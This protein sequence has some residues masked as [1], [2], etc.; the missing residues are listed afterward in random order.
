MHAFNA[1]VSSTKTFVSSAKCI[2]SPHG[3]VFVCSTINVYAI[4]LEGGLEENTRKRTET[5]GKCFYKTSFHSRAQE[6]RAAIDQTE[7]ELIKKC[8]PVSRRRNMIFVQ[9]EEAKEEQL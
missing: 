7:N 9:E 1:F 5:R 3:K 4:Y 6:A 8:A 2:L